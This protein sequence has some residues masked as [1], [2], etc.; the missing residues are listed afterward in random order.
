MKL[1]IV[2]CNGMLGTDMVIEAKKAGHDVRGIDFPQIDIT[3]PQSVGEIVAEARP[4]AIINCAAYT[5]V[6]ACET[7][8]ET[9]FAVNARGPT[10]LAA[11]ASECGALLVHYSTDYV[12][13]GKKTSP[14]VESDPTSPLTVYG[15]SKLEGERLAF[16]CCERTIVLRIAWLY[17]MTGTNFVKTIRSAA[18]KK[19]ASGEPLRVVNDQW[20]TP[21]WTVPVCL[22]TFAL[23]TADQ[24][25]VYHA[26]CEGACTW[27]DFTVE[28]LRQAGI[29]TAVE[30]CTTA[31]YPRPAPR[32]LFSVLENQ[33]LKIVGLNRMPGWK[34]AFR[35]FVEAETTQPAI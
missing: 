15:R 28:I 9:A 12:F 34:E 35:G 10:N 19:A 24:Y 29:T 6:D 8:A 25:G 23:L 11:V 26:T 7:N 16:E 21:T 33:R 20:G 27:F 13:D 4:E 5:A 30:P 31:E 18:L 1:L 14:Y 2:G 3:K 17:G 32:P 22:Q